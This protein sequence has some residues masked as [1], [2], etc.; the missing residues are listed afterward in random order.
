[1]NTYL[2]NNKYAYKYI[3]IL[4]INRYKDVSHMPLIRPS[5]DAVFI[6]CGFYELLF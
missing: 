4:I 6:L 1:M 5:G 3:Y 2:I